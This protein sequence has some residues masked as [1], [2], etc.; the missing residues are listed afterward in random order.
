MKKLAL[1]LLLTILISACG[2]SEKEVNMIS[3]SSYNNGYYDALD[4]V[5][6]K[7]G[8]AKSAAQACE[9]E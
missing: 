4:C 1:L 6:R 8:N 7:G 3:E 5:K 9:N 2:K